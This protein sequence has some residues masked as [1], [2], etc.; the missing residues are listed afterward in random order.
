[1]APPPRPASWSQVPATDLSQPQQSTRARR[2]DPPLSQSMERLSI[3]SSVASDLPPATGYNERYQESTSF[4]YSTSSEQSGFAAFAPASNVGPPPP[5]GFQSQLPAGR[6]HRGGEV[7]SYQ[8]SL[9]SADEVVGDP[10][11][12]GRES[13]SSIQLESHWITPRGDQ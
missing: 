3:L 5:S 10:W 1:M 12:Q 6:Y 4:A 8:T 2:G 11:N 7:S 9:P 13:P